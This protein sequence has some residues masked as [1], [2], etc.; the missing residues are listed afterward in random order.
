[1]A[2]QHIDQNAILQV[3]PL[4]IHPSEATLDRADQVHLA[5]LRSGHL[6]L[7]MK[8]YLDMRGTPFYAAASAYAQHPWYIWQSNTTQQDNFK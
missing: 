6:I 7:P 3:P 8:D 4:E 1:M 5:I 2:I